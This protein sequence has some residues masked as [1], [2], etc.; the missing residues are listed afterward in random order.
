MR[1]AAERTRKDWSAVDSELQAYEE[2]DQT[3]YSSL[4]ENG[5]ESLLAYWHVSFITDLL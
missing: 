5:T 4:L 1:A 3:K 2:E